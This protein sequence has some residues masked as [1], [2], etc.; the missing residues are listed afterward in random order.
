MQKSAAFPNHLANVEVAEIE[1]GIVVGGLARDERAVEEA[2]EP[3]VQT[4][5][6]R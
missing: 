4:V 3:T 1:I 6:L 5:G 2:V